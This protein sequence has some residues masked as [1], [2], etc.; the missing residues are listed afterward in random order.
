MNEDESIVLSEQWKKELEQFPFVS[1]HKG[2]MSALLKSKSKV[3]AVNKSRVKYDAFD[4]I[5][6]PRPRLNSPSHSQNLI[7]QTPAP[8]TNKGSKK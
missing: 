4:F 3:T 1:K 5:Q 2:R 8:S 7:Q 6:G